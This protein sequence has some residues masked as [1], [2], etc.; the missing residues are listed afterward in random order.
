[1]WAAV[2]AIAVLPCA[3]GAGIEPAVP[4]PEVRLE[5]LGEP[6]IEDANNYSENTAVRI[7]LLRDGVPVRGWT[8]V[9]RIEEWN[10]QVYDGLHG[11]TRL[12]L[13]VSA[14]EG[15]AVVVLKS[16]AR[17]AHVDMRNMPVPQ[18]AVSAGGPPQLLQI[19]QWVDAD[20]NDKT[21]W[22]E[23]RVDALLR[24]ARASDEPQIARAARLIRGWEQSFKRD[25]GGFD[26]RRPHLISVSPACMDFDGV[27][28]HRLNRGF[29][30]S[31][32]VLH[33]VWH[34]W[35]YRQAAAQPTGK[36]RWPKS[37]PRPLDMIPC[38]NGCVGPVWLADPRYEAEEDEAEAF[39]DRFKHLFP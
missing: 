28:S 7:R 38:P 39:A 11:A 16:L 27:D 8:G 34:A 31:A 26:E 4:P 23:H 2:A 9:I 12:P 22:L 17:Y 20:G 32:T 21:D 29:E 14:P 37:P 33:E 6:V 25:C 3:S 35:S 1:M 24:Q 10:T 13:E 15:E 19:P 5:R 36:R 18:V 30:L